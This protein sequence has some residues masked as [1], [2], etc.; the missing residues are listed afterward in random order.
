MSKNQIAPELLVKID[1][2]PGMRYKYHQDDGHILLVDTAQGVAD[3]VMVFGKG[4]RALEHLHM[5]VMAVEGVLAHMGY[6]DPASGTINV[7]RW[8]SV[9]WLHQELWDANVN[10]IAFTETL[11]TLGNDIIKES[12]VSDCTY[13]RKIRPVFTD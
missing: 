12:I 9:R 13:T 11:T 4:A 6:E 1:R 3:R 7:Y 8:V 5:A 2:L 10:I